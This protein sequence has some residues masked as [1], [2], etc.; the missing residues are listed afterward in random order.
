MGS[1][2]D[3]GEHKEQ[4]AEKIT[5]EPKSSRCKGRRKNLQTKDRNK[6]E[7]EEPATLQR[8]IANSEQGGEM[9]VCIM[10]QS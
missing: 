7:E 6:G 9:T 8:G 2:P 5:K 3:Q 4:R 10:G 1:W